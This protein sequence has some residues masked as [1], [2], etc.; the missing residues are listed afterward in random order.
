MIEVQP[1]VFDFLRDLQANN[2]REW[3]HANKHRY[4][5]ARASFETFTAE[6]IKLVAGIDPSIGTPSVKDCIYRIFRDLRFTNDKTPYKPNFCCVAALGGRKS[7]LPGYYI[8]FEPDNCYFGGGIYCVTPED[9]RRVR[10]EICNFPEEFVAAVESPAFKERMWFFEDRLKVFPK[11]YETGFYG[12]KYLKYKMF[13]WATTYTDE[14]CLSKDL[15]AIIANDIR[16][17]KPVNDFLRRAL[18][19]PEEEHVDF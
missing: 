14:Q 13:A 4:D 15:P 3:F 1:F 12:D 8:S 19:A 9:L 7:R 5:E 6:F 11:G 18:D 10:T 16:I 2:N 17:G